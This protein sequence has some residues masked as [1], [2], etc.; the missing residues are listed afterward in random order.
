LLVTCESK[1]FIKELAVLIVAREL[2]LQNNNTRTYCVFTVILA[3]S[4]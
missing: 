4:R 1:M 3:C 2:Q